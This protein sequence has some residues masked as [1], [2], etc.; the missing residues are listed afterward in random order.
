M[1]FAEKVT[2][3]T[4]CFGYCWESQ[5]SLPTD[6]LF[7]GQRLDTTGLYY[8]RAPSVGPANINPS[9][10]GTSPLTLTGL[11][12]GRY[13][14]PTIGRFISPDTIIPELGDPQSLNRY[15]YVKNNPLK[16]NDPDG[17]W[18]NFV[19]GALI[20]MVSYAAV[21]VA[22]NWLQGDDLLEGWNWVDF[23][24][25]TIIG[26]L[27]GGASEITTITKALGTVLAEEYFPVVFGAA[28]G[29]V[30]YGCDLVEGQANPEDFW[31]YFYGG[32]FSGVTEV[33]VPGNQLIQSASGAAAQ[34]AA[35]IFQGTALDDLAYSP[36]PAGYIPPVRPP[37]YYDEM[38]CMIY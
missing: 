37:I 29:V 26:S 38:G 4:V 18:I 6:K 21:T 8:Y 7:T 35:D 2:L 9:I 11:W 10:V 31:W 22:V 1:V 20:G 34:A 32:F 12:A 25:S 28:G 36:I 5:G 27:T 24:E 19:I 23:A 16:Y 30:Q 15:T 17:H 13:Y 14:D 33:A 3:S